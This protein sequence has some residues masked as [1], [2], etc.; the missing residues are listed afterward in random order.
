MKARTRATKRPTISLLFQSRFKQTLVLQTTHWMHLISYSAS[1]WSLWDAC[2]IQLAATGAKVSSFLLHL[3]AVF[4]VRNRQLIARL[5]SYPLS[6][7]HL[8]T[9]FILYA[10]GTFFHPVRQKTLNAA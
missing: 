2:E 8:I 7:S 3:L 6:T 1:A 4:P 5:V 9:T 10:H